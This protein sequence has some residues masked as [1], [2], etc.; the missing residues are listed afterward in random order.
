MSELLNKYSLVLATE[1]KGN[2]ATHMC[3]MFPE[4]RQHLN[5]LKT[6]IQK[7]IS[8]ALLLIFLAHNLYVDTS[9]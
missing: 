2:G 4:K 6:P 7:L 9:G 5:G 1:S 8:L 3:K